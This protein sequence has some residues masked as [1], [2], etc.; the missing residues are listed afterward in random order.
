MSKQIGS[1]HRSNSHPA[2]L[3]TP[4]IPLFAFSPPDSPQ[5]NIP[6]S[7]NSDTNSDA[8]VF[9]TISQFANSDIETPNEF[10]DS[11]PSPST[12]SQA[13]STL[14]SQP[15]FDPFNHRL[16]AYHRLPTPTFPK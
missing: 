13:S 7:M 3:Q 12:T 14:C 10:A 1:L 8:T 2:N 4:I 9:D 11:E 15:L 5:I 6:S 16:I